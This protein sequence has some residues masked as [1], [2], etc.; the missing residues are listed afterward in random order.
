MLLSSFSG[1]NRDS[2]QCLR[3]VV[4]VGEFEIVNPRRKLE[5]I[6]SFFVRQD[7]CSRRSGRSVCGKR[8]NACL[9]EG[10]LGVAVLDGTGN[11]SL[12]ALSCIFTRV[13]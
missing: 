8:F 13:Q 11:F 4:R 3:F 7:K 9:G 5:N 10:G 12:C 6:K 1:D 2:F